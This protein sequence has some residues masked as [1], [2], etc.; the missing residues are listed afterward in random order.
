MS[1]ETIALSTIYQESHMCV[2]KTHTTQ[3]TLTETHTTGRVKNIYVG[4]LD[5]KWDN[6]VGFILF[7]IAMEM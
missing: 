6:I 5:C 2:R 7:L 1:F 3:T 4:I